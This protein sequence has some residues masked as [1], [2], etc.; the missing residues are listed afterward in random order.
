MF[1]RIIVLSVLKAPMLGD[2]SHGNSE[3]EIVLDDV[4]RAVE[5]VPGVRGELRGA[6]GMG[7][8]SPWPA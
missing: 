7:P 1:F 6:V 8:L 4:D 3:G 2:A 5:M